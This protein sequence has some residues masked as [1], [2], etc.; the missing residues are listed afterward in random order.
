MA[1][2]DVP[3]PDCINL[4]VR[5]T[6]RRRSED[7]TAL[8]GDIYPNQKWAYS[9]REFRLTWGPKVLADVDTFIAFFEAIG[10]DTFRM[11]D[12]QDYRSASVGTDITNLDQII[13]VGDGV[14]TEFQLVK[15]YTYLT[16]THNA[17]IHAPV[18]GSVVIAVD[19]V[20][21]TSPADFSVDYNTGMVTFIAAPG[22]SLVITAGFEYDCKVRLE[23]DSI[24]ERF[25]A[26]H[27]GEI[28]A[29]TLVEN[30]R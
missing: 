23:D 1:F 18:S 12:P 11:R 8:S 9:R 7:V 30:P 3:Y 19:G 6:R 2:Q 4:D 14:E 28:D 22:N 20:A 16:L 29:F 27:L 21:Q 13:G 17:P 26:R 25:R 15:N 10:R 24:I 5:V